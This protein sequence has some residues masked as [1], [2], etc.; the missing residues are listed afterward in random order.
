MEL[1]PSDIA[2]ARI[3]CLEYHG[4][5]VR[6]DGRPYAVHPMAVADILREHGYDDPVTQCIALLHDTREDT[7]LR[8]PEIRECF[9]FEVAN[10]VYVL[11]R[12]AAPGGSLL[13]EEQ[14]FWRLS[15][16]RRKVRRVKIADAVH[17]TLDLELL[18]V[19]GVMRKFWEAEEHLLPWA[20]EIAPRLGRRLEQNLTRYL[21]RAG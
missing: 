1:G 13:T 21:T 9:G 7:A 2:R 4:A 16:S 3:F 8:I 10:G 15:Q 5:Q 11:S 18:T 20:R 14:Y 6:K 12:N 19:E 17:N